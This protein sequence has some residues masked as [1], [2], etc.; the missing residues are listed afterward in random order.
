[1]E[2]S[3]KP[4]L[5]QA[6]LVG[7]V[8]VHWEE[9][10]LRSILTTPPIAG[11]SGSL[12]DFHFTIHRPLVSDGEKA[13]YLEAKCPDSA[14]KIAASKILLKNEAGVPGLGATTFL[15]GTFTVPCTPSAASR[16]R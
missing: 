4:G 16:H 6:S 7:V 3:V 1:L 13:G 8:R 14:F 15:K 9:E 2:V 5:A 12:L 10:G 11:G